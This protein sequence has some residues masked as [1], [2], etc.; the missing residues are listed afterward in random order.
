VTAT[1]DATGFA[2]LALPSGR[3]RVRAEQDGLVRS[4]DEAVVVP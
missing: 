4:F 1:A 2:R 3:R